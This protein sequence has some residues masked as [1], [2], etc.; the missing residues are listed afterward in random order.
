[1]NNEKSASFGAG[2]QF[3]RCKRSVG[4]SACTQI[5]SDPSAAVLRS[6]FLVPTEKRLIAFS[7]K[8]CSSLYRVSDQ[9]PLTGGSLPLAKVTVYFCLELS[10][11]PLASRS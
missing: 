2:S 9:K 1:M 10:R 6:L 5:V 8:K 3:D 11:P 4:S 7:A